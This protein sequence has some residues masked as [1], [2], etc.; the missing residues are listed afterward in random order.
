MI[1]GPGNQRIERAESGK[2]CEIPVD[3]G[4]RS[5]MFD[6][7]RS[8]MRVRSQGS[9]RLAFHKQA[10]ED[11]PVP[12]SSAQHRHH[13]VFE[14]SRNNGCCLGDGKRALEHTLIS[15]DA[16]ES[17]NDYPREGH[18]FALRKLVSSHIR[19]AS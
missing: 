7:Q 2:T 4:E 5:S 12:V 14:P 11:L 3:G 17:K 13:R 8:Q 19:A 6:A 16:Q 10:S 9:G 1:L 15:A 18:R